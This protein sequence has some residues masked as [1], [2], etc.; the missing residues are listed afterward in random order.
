MQIMKKKSIYQTFVVKKL[1]LNLLKIDFKFIKNLCA[2]TYV[3]ILPYITYIFI[4]K[5]SNGS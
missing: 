2:N 5:V 3:R 1:I 4:K